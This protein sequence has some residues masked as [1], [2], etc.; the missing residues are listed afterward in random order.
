MVSNRGGI[1][2]L[3]MRMDLC[4]HMYGSECMYARVCIRAWVY[5]YALLYGYACVCYTGICICSGCVWIICMLVMIVWLTLYLSICVYVCARRYV[6]MYLCNVCA[7]IYIYHF[8]N[9]TIIYY[10]QA[11]CKTVYC[12]L[13]YFQNIIHY[14]TQVFVT[15]NMCSVRGGEINSR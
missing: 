8:N 5:V 3:R 15:S 12:N 2:C 11:H 4:V 1:R 7:R 14:V 13:N 6:G 10:I 9:T